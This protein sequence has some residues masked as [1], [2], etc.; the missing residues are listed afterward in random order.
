M[1]SDYYDPST[2]VSMGCALN[3]VVGA[4]SIGKT[5]SFKNFIVK[6]FLKYEEEAV[7]AR[8]FKDDLETMIDFWALQRKLFPKVTFDMKVVN[9]TLIGFI[10]EK[11][12]VYF[13]PVNRA[14][15]RKS[16]FSFDNVRWF[17]YDE[18]LADGNSYCSK[19]PEQLISL[20]WTVK[21]DKTVKDFQVFLLGNAVELENPHFQYFNI[22]I[23]DPNRRFT[24]NDKLWCVENVD[25][26]TIP[27]LQKIKEDVWG[28]LVKDTTYG[29]YSLDNKY[30]DDNNALI[31]KRSSDAYQIDT[32]V[33]EGESFYIWYSSKLTSLYIDNKGNPNGKQWVINESDLSE[34]KG[35]YKDINKNTK[36]FIQNCRKSGSLFF[37]SREI[38]S[39][40]LKFLKILGIY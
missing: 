20:I 38:R 5:E 36:Q 6:R 10:N 27:V 2:I 24:K 16:G 9:K 15:K 17:I 8:R 1:S 21:R 40:S 28:Q 35:Y 14:Q 12:A 19:E 4:R 7:Y 26:D 23:D 13:L 30:S 18:F 39:K 33:F 37:T 22:S 11:P 31:R 32:I 25:S 34:G 29:A 3:V